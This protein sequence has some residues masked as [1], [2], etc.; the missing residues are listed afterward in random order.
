MTNDANILDAW[1]YTTYELI[2]N[3]MNTFYNGDGYSESCNYDE[4][5]FGFQN[6]TRVWVG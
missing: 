4:N 6:F 5:E 1:N 3:D 2:Y